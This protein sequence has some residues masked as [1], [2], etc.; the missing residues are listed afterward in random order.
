MIV[1]YNITIKYIIAYK[2]FNNKYDKLKLVKLHITSFIFSASKGGNNNCSPLVKYTAIIFPHLL[3]IS[4]SI[5]KL[6]LKKYIDKA[7]KIV[8]MF[9]INVEKKN[10]RDSNISNL[11]NVNNRENDIKLV[12]SIPFKNNTVKNNNDCNSIIKKIVAEN[13]KN[14]PKI[15]SYLLIGLLKI[16]K[17]VFHSISLNS[18]CDHTNNTDTNQKI[19]IIDNQKSTIILLSSQIVS[20]PKATEKTMNTK[21]KNNIKYKNLFLTISLNVFNAIFN[22]CLKIYNLKN[23]CF[24]LQ[25]KVYPYSFFIQVLL[26]LK[27]IFIIYK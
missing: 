16:K 9:H 5:V 24:N 26:D 7:T 6:W 13:Q 10:T 25:M 11:K 15:N 8:S 1:R 21:A 22:I 4:I 12:I 19:S 14:L 18:N 20:C 17:I 23:L 3:A 27:S 2:L